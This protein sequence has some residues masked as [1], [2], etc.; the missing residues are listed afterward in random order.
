MSAKNDRKSIQKTIAETEEAIAQLTSTLDELKLQL[1]AQ[2]QPKTNTNTDAKS[3]QKRRE[4][5]VGDRVIV[6]SRYRNRFGT[7]GTVLKVTRS[8]YVIDPDEGSKIERQF[9]VHHNNVKRIEE[10]QDV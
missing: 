3:K 1:Q 7:K 10:G 5:Q 9:R 4:I 8:Q 2:S 6:Q